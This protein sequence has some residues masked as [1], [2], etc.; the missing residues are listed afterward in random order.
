MVD[1]VGRCDLV[2]EVCDDRWASTILMKMRTY[3][4]Q[5]GSRHDGQWFV[6]VGCTALKLCGV[7][8]CVIKDCPFAYFRLPFDILQVTDQVCQAYFKRLDLYLTGLNS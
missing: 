5:V 8:G 3:I 4:Q 1:I 6:F 2:C 7:L